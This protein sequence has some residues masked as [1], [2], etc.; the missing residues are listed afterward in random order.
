MVRVTYLSVSCLVVTL[1]QVTFANY[2]LSSGSGGDSNECE[3]YLAVSGI[4][5]SGFGVYTTS[6]I[7]KDSHIYSKNQG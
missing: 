3:E 2:N 6:K 5:N 4:P 7:P 1:L